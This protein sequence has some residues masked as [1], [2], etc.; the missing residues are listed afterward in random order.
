MESPTPINCGGNQLCEELI[1][2]HQRRL[3]YLP[4]QII[5]SS[6]YVSL[7]F[8]NNDINEETL[9]GQDTTRRTNGIIV[10]EVVR[11]CEPPPKLVN[12]S[13]KQTEPGERRKR[14]LEGP[15]WCYQTFSHF[16]VLIHHQ[17]SYH[18]NLPPRLFQLLNVTESCRSFRVALDYHWRISI[19]ANH[20]G[21]SGKIPETQGFTGI[22]EKTPGFSCN[23]SRTRAI[24]RT[25]KG[26]WKVYFWCSFVEG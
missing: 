14:S 19:L 16:P 21:F 12:T 26:F 22:S 24:P 3:T 13:S 20:T 15:Q 2:K 6:A 17:E 23:T 5:P 1:I 7:A 25:F 9:S 11:G 18:Q 4:P 8:D 10:P